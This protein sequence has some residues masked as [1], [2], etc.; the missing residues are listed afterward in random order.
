M[1]GGGGG[2]GVGYHR[3]VCVN[4][5]VEPLHHFRWRGGA[6]NNNN[7]TERSSFELIKT[8]MRMTKGLRLN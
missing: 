4:T 3:P 2:G 6:D 8:I 1:G 5:I 7:M